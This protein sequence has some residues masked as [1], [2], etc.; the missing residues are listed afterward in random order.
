[1]FHFKNTKEKSY[2]FYKKKI[3]KYCILFIGL[4]LV[5]SCSSDDSNTTNRQNLSFTDIYTIQA[6]TLEMDMISN[7]GENSIYISYSADNGYNENLLKLNVNTLNTNEIIL[8]DVAES[9]QIE[10]VNN[11]IF[12]LSGNDIFKL[13]LNLNLISTNNR[14]NESYLPRI[15]SRNNTIEIFRG[16]NNILSYDILT[17][18]YIYPSFPTNSN[19]FLR[20]DVE[21]INDKLFTFGG[22][23]YVNQNWVISNQINIYNYALNSWSSQ[24]LPFNAYETFTDVYDNKIIV[25]GNKQNN[26][27]DAFIGI[28][29]PSNGSYTNFSTTI[30][31][32]AISLRGLTVLNDELYIAYLDYNSPLP[33]SLSIKIAKASL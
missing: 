32:N 8:P 1:M 17:D 18:N 14:Y 29:D 27:S 13:D 4:L 24:N 20:A 3:M 28:Y 31:L 22:L 21:I 10:I 33:N 12:S 30:N 16:I 19:Y 26:Q 7:I 9:R 11:N 5:F 15:T 23:N 25:G 6:D 2:S